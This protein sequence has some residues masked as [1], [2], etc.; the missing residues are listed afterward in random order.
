MDSHTY[1]RLEQKLSAL[2]EQDERQRVENRRLLLRRQIVDELTSKRFRDQKSRQD[3]IALCLARAEKANGEDQSI[4]ELVESLS[5]LRPTYFK[6]V[7]P[8]SETSP[9]VNVNGAIGPSP[10][11]ST[12]AFDTDRLNDPNCSEAERDEAAVEIGRVLLGLAPNGRFRY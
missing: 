5:Q 10:A 9:P 6:P 4:S 12:K 1:A 2:R 11:T 8:A 3:F 7:Q